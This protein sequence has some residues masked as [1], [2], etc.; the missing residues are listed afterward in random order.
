MTQLR[1]LA[2]L[3][4]SKNAGPFHLTFDTMF[5]DLETFYRVCEAN[6]LTPDRIGKLYNTKPEHVQVIPY[7][8]AAAIKVTIPRPI[9]QNDLG[10]GD[11]QGGAQYVP[12]AE[13]DIPD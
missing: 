7:E 8:A 3:I 1:D 11:V 12:L 6:V 2:I 13:L 5:A 10:E 9:T 4:R